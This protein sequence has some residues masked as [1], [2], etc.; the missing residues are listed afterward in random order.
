[1]DTEAEAAAASVLAMGVTESKKVAL[2][3]LELS[4]GHVEFAVEMILEGH[5]SALEERRVASDRVRILVKSPLGGRGK[6]EA[7]YRVTLAVRPLPPPGADHVPDV[8]RADCRH[9]HRRACHASI[10]FC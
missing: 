7:S 3:A 8:S 1:M 10:I 4:G 9:L 2:A 6:I 5:F